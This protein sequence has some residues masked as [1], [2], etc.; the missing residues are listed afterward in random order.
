LE[1]P[2]E[3]IVYLLVAEAIVSATGSIAKWTSAA[4]RIWNG[5]FCIGTVGSAKV[6][7]WRV[8]KW[9]S[10]A[11]FLYDLSVGWCANGGE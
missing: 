7:T 3:L 1:K 8:A 10:A 5:V 9:A 4:T 11:Y 2:K 6:A